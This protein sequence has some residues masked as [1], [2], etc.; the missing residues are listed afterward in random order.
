MRR[1]LLIAFL[2]SCFAVVSV[3]AVEINPAGKIYLLDTSARILGM[4]GCGSL[5]GD[6]SSGLYNPA[7][8]NI[9]P[10]AAGSLYWNP[11]PAFGF[12]HDFVAVSLAASSEFGHI[13]FSYLVRDGLEDSYYPPEE[14][15]SFVIAGRPSKKLNLHLGL[16]FKILVTE[17]QQVPFTPI[18]DQNTKAY[19]MGFDLG[20]VYSGLF[21]ETTSGG[22][23]PL[24]NRWRSRFGLPAER[25]I[26]VGAAFLNLGGE[27]DYENTVVDAPLPQT[28]RG[29][30]LWNAYADAVYGLKVA[31]QFQKMLVG[32]KKSDNPEMPGGY[33]KASDA[34][35]NAW[36]GGSY[37]GPWTTRFGVEMT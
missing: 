7:A 33:Y 26:S 6:A 8:Q 15:T 4:G 18:N 29:D 35:F 19:K 23:D 20:A 1:L 37:E 36:G 21:P 16:G 14:A 17:P 13:A 22:I 24:R 5:I 30:L 9:N 27:V 12:N 34:I 32:R 11:D 3:Q 2:I 31:L 10:D 28:F 25:G